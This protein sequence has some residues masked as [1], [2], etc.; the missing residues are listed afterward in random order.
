[1]RPV[2]AAVVA[3][4][5]LVMLSTPAVAQRSDDAFKWYLGAQAGVLG[6][7]TP[8]QTR[9]WAPTVGGQLLVMAKRTGLMVSIEEAFGKNEVTGY[10][11]VNANAGVR[12]VRFDRIRKYSAILTAYPVK[13]STQP[14]F[15]LGFGLMQVLNPKPQGFFTS[16][17][18][19][20]L[21]G[22]LASTKSTDGFIAAV[23]GV[24]FRA[25]RMVA[26]GQAQLSS[27]AK[28][29]HLL[30]GAGQAVTGGLRFSLGGAK[31]GVH[32]GGY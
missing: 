28:S 18:Q 1:M 27:S 30:Q 24:Q 13:G 2:R 17:V 16:P 3:I 6:F 22:R 10:G 14:Y 31:E 26:F 20:T 7:E 19:A 32:G 23:A 12:E 25:G 29:G 15:G 4:S 8:S 9:A 21:A 5:G 11:D